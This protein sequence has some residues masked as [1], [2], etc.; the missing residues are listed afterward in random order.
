MHRI[1]PRSAKREAAAAGLGWRQ[2]APSSAHLDRQIVCWGGVIDS[3]PFNRAGKKG[4]L[5]PDG[6]SYPNLGSAAK[7]RVYPAISSNPRPSKI[8]MRAWR[9][10]LPDN[11]NRCAM[12]HWLP[13]LML[14]FAPVTINPRHKQTDPKQVE[15]QLG[16]LHRHCITLCRLGHGG[17]VDRLRQYGKDHVID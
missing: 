13:F 11:T 8:T 6:L 16:H 17:L 12:R 7:I 14:L 5:A 10:R 2:S 15:E 3:E 4:T 9:R 1:A